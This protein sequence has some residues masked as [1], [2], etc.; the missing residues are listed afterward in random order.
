MSGLHSGEFRGLTKLVKITVDVR[1][2]AARQKISEEEVMQ[3]GVEQ[4]AKELANNGREIYA[5]A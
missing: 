3:V 1:I 2:F 4:K 5:K